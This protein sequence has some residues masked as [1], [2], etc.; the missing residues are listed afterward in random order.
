MQ[1]DPFPRWGTPCTFVSPAYG[2]LLLS[3]DCTA[4]TGPAQDGPLPIL[5]G[6]LLRAA[7]TLIIACD[8]ESG[9]GPCPA[10]MDTPLEW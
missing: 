5:G 6:S 1:E 10:S 7:L 4:D 3:S 8:H 9:D 2:Q